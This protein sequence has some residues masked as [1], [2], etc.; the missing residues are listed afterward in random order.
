MCDIFNPSQYGF[1]NDMP[2]THALVKVVSENF[3]LNKRKHSIGVFID[4][5]KAFDTVDHQR[6]CEKFA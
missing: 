4:L 3:F 5:R 1:R 6:L 2:I